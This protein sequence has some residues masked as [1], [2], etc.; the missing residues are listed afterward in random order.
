MIYENPGDRELREADLVALFDPVVIGWHQVLVDI[1]KDADEYKV[2]VVVD[3]P[4]DSTDG[5][6]V[7]TWRD[8]IADARK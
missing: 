4:V 1:T 8:R 6:A 2:F 5:L 3:I 7:Q